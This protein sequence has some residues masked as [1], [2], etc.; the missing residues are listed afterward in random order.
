MMLLRQIRLHIDLPGSTGR[1]PS[2]ILPSAPS[3][4][5]DIR[6]SV[7]LESADKLVCA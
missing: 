6:P 7:P 4:D 3:P 2:S 5:K 1:F